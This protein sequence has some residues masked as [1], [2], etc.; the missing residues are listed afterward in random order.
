MDLHGPL[1][2]KLLW[3][4]LASLVL[5]L[6][7]QGLVV[8]LV[9]WPLNISGV[10]FGGWMQLTGNFRPW[11]LFTH[12]MINSIWDLI[13]VALTLL[14][15]GGQLESMWG[16][17]RYG[18]FLGTCAIGA[19][20]LQWL[21]STLVFWAGL[22]PYQPSAGASG[23][24]YAILFALAYLAPYSP[25]RLLIPPV[26]MQMRT[27]AIVFAVIA[28]VFGVRGQGIW[29]QFGFLGGMLIAW[30]HIRYWRGD[31]PFGRKKPKKPPPK[32]RIVG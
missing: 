5:S 21:V 13:F 10:E 25:V 12:L 3:A 23:L 26:T 29:A 22:A 28:F 24:M 30:L 16:T 11:Q 6:L 7:P 17:R 2:V 20:L 9:L 19:A 8:Q 18:W 14:Y 1:T 4:T 32:F 31:P 15:F 27:L